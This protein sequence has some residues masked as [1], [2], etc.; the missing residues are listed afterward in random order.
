MFWKSSG[1]EMFEGKEVPKGFVGSE[2]SRR[3]KDDTRKPA[4]ALGQQEEA[5]VDIET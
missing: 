3:V 4:R 5:G 2:G 1:A